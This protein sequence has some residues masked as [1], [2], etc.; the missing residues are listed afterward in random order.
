MTQNT[1]LKLLV[2]SIKEIYLKNKELFVNLYNDLNFK[3]EFHEKVI[4]SI[5][6]KD[7][8]KAKEAFESYGKLALE[9][10]KDVN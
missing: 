10:F 6:V 5:L 7:K 3:T 2:N 4:E 9:V 8:L 1:A